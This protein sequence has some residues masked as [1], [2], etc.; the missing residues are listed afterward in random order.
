AMSVTARRVAVSREGLY[1]VLAFL[2]RR[3]ARTSP[4]AVRFELTPGQPVQ[5]VLEPWEVRI[6]LHDTPYTGAETET[7][8]TWGRDRLLALARVVPLAGG[9]DVFV[10]GTGLPSCWSVRLGEMR[11]L[12]GLSG[13]TANDWTSGGGALADLAPPAEPSEDLLGDITSAF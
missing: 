2:K 10:R 8:R 6:R 4:R 5:I 3:R 13:W 7:I 11:L 12:L 1:N 9:A